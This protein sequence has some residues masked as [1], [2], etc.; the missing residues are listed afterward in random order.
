[1]S[2]TKTAQT[3]PGLSDMTGVDPHYFGHRERLR[4]RMFN[5][6]AETLPDYEL[7]EVLLFTN[8]PRQDV[9]PLAK[10]LI[11]RFGSFG[12]VL[13]ADPEVLRAAKLRDPT[14]AI[15][16]AVREAALRLGKAELRE[17]SVIGSW[18]RLIAYCNAHVAYSPVEE[19]HLLFLNRKNALL[20][21][22][23]QQ[24]GT[25]D[26]TPVYVREVVKRA[27]DLNAS[28]LILVHNHPS[29]DPTPSKADIAVTRDIIK[30]AAPLGVL[31]HDHVIVGRG[32]HTSLRDLGLLS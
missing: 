18:D 4:D 13:S 17:G 25:I 21:H 26:H 6:G 5:G 7:L 10:A 19:F 30:A 9:K 12:Q 20:A 23:R 8:N 24:R 31:V 22:E 1:M 28:A 32:H 14:I 29:G 15:L 2:R 16:K 27:L 3:S 11:E